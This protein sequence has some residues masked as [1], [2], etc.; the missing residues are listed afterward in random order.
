[1]KLFIV[2]TKIYIVNYTKIYVNIVVMAH[3]TIS[4]CNVLIFSRNV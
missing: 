4:S 3:I 2:I 1:M